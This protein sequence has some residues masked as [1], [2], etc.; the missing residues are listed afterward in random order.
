MNDYE[1]ITVATHKQ[2]KFDELINNRFQ[3]K[4][5]VLGMGKNWTGFNMKYELVYEYIKNMNDDKIII[6]LDGFDSIIQNDP[7]NAVKI[8]KRKNYK[9][10]FSN[11]FWLRSNFM[12]IYVSSFVFPYC[13]ENTSINSGMYMGYVKYLKQLLQD[14]L[15][16]KCKD[17]QRVINTLCK[18]NDFILV[19][20]DNDIFYNVS[21]DKNEKPPNKS[22][23]V[24]FPGTLTMNRAYRAIFEYG[25]FFLLQFAFICALILITLVYNKRYYIAF[26]FILLVISYLVNIDYSCL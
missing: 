1:I 15:K 23:F 26:V 24:S 9:T 8:F 6:F 18:K 17:D 22:I 20:V 7:S 13:H 4:V 19:D 5:T 12:R 11:D 10:L 16:N 3:E 21:P 2:G 25:Q 14:S